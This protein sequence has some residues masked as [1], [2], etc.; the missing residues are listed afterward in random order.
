ML[1]RNDI[2]VAHALLRTFCTKFEELYGTDYCTPNM[3]LH[4]HLKEC[5]LDFG[6]P[7]AFWCFA[8]ERC[9]GI[10][11]SLHTNNKAIEVQVMKKFV[12]GQKLKGLST[13]DGIDASIR[14]LLP[15]KTID[16]DF[17]SSSTSIAAPEIEECAYDYVLSSL[18]ALKFYDVQFVQCLPPAK[19]KFLSSN[20]LNCLK[21]I[22]EQLYSASTV[23][24]APPFYTCYGRVTLYGDVIGSVLNR[25]SSQSSSVVMA[26]WPRYGS[27][28]T[29]IRGRSRIFFWWGHKF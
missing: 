19:E 28:I 14:A 9:N 10:L 18:D 17:F 13:N 20:L 2:D 25:V 3:H 6:P 16:I 15:I 29:V 21:C 23:I 22:Y 26:Y 27:D 24:Y 11:G 12:T 8:F 5:L 4:L 1:K 7:H